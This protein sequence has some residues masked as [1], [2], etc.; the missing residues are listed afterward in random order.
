MKYAIP[1][2]SEDGEKW[3]CIINTDT[4]PHSLVC[5]PASKVVVDPFS[6]VSRPPLRRGW[7]EGIYLTKREKRSVYR[8]KVAFTR[9]EVRDD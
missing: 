2:R 8:S 1:F 3:W 4:R 5:L 7:D 9:F 6:R